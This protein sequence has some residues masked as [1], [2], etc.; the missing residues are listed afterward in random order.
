MNIVWAPR[1]PWWTALCDCVLRHKW[2]KLSHILDLSPL[3][4][5]SHFWPGKNMQTHT[6]NLSKGRMD[7]TPG[8]LWRSLQGLRRKISALLVRFETPLP[9]TGA[10]CWYYRTPPNN[11][12]H[13]KMS[14]T[15]VYNGSDKGRQW[16]LWPKSCFF[17]TF[18][19][20][21]LGCTVYSTRHS[22]VHSIVQDILWHA[23]E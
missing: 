8:K 19:P 14:Y 22:I 3:L 11:N 9:S 15:R 13:K 21:L 1:D 20:E 7:R 17:E 12:K 18:N 5:R 10:S 2:W 4:Y 6:G 23:I 16:K